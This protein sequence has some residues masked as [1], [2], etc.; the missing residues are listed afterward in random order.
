MK[1]LKSIAFLS[2]AALALSSSTLQAKVQLHLDAGVTTLDLGAI[3]KNNEESIKQAKT[4]GFDV[5]QKEDL[6]AIFVDLD[7]DFMIKENWFVGPSI[8]YILGHENST[9]YGLSGIQFQDIYTPNMMPIMLKFGWQGP[10]TE[11]GLYG[12]ATL[13][14]GYGMMTFNSKGGFG[15]QY[16]DNYSASGLIYELDGRFGH[17]WKNFSVGLGLGYRY[18]VFPEMSRSSTTNPGLVDKIGEKAKDSNG[19]LMQIDMSG[20]KGNLELGVS[21]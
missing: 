7:I 19:N 21:F 11:Q 4:A 12:G 3:K 6:S 20:L 17:H 8:G 13:G 15:T 16:E 5:Q 14:L 18:A 2:F 9:T 10:A 1:T